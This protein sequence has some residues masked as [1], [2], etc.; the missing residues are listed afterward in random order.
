RDLSPSPSLLVSDVVRDEISRNC[1]KTADPKEI[2]SLRRY[3]QQR[4]SKPPIYVYGKMKNYVGRR[5]Y[6]ALQEL[7]HLSRAFRVY[8]APGSGSGDR[9]L[10]SSYVRFQQEHNVD[11]ILLTFD[12]RIQAIA[13]PYG[14]SSILV[15]Q[16][17]NVTSASYDHIK[18][19]W[20]LYILT[21]YFIS[22]RINGDVGWIRLIGEWRGKSTEEWINGI[23]YIESE[24]KIVEKISVVHGKLFKLQNL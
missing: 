22:I 14:L 24:E 1:N 20:L 5:A 23:I 17:E 18:L 16:S 15:E 7:D 12:R 13:H 21:I 8:N 2:S 19:P 4:L 10:I 6:V 11:A 3:F 9:A